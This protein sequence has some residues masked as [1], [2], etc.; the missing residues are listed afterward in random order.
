MITI[1]EREGGMKFPKE[2]VVY[3]DDADKIGD[4]DKE[5]GII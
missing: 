2:Y 5:R 4:W 3:N 1:E